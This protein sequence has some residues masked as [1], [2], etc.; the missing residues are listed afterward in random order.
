MNINT[1]SKVNIIS[2]VNT[3]P[4]PNSRH[5]ITSDNRDHSRR[6]YTFCG[7]ESEAWDGRIEAG[8]AGGGIFVPQI[9]FPLVGELGITVPSRGGVGDIMGTQPASL[10]GGWSHQCVI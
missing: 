6:C 3:Y 10:N 7:W 1:C 4:T 2:E 9:V 5:T 8:Q